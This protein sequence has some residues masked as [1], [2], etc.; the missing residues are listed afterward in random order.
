MRTVLWLLSLI[1]PLPPPPPIPSAEF[2][3]HVANLSSRSWKVR[4]RA[5]QSLHDLG[6]KAIPCLEVR[7]RASADLETRTRLARICSDLRANRLRWAQRTVQER[8]GPNYPMVDALWLNTDAASYDRYGGDCWCAWRG[9]LVGHYL[10]RR[11][12]ENYPAEDRRRYPQFRDGT[13]DLFIDLLDREVPVWLVDLLCVEMWRRDN[14][15]WRRGVRQEPDPFWWPG[16]WPQKGF[17]IRE[18]T[19]PRAED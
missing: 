11:T 2:D 8:Y 14:I 6:W 1:L 7:G 9:Q 12:A 15:W 10:D 19:M 5:H 18:I 4:E 3:R 13:R 16:W 17:P